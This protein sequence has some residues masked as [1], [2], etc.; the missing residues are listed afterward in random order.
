METQ[1][2]RTPLVIIGTQ[3]IGRLVLEAC[4]SI[5]RTV[6]CFINAEQSNEN[7]P[8][9]INNISVLGELDNIEILRM[10]GEKA[11]YFVALEE[12][13][14]RQNIIEMLKKKRKA[15]PANIIHAQVA[16]SND[17]EFGHGNYFAPFVVIEPNTKIH[18]HCIIHAGT[19]IGL[20]SEIKDFATIGAR[21]SIGAHAHIGENVYIGAGAIISPKIKI[22][23][24][25]QVLAGAVVLKDVEKGQTVFGNPALPIKN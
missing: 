13:Q 12:K 16:L 10:I 7:E 20:N 2:Q 5:D 9:E 3:A 8:V 14:A 6:Y 17:A 15:M 11:H 19:T 25:A 21:V 24:N 4:H 18:N 22:G 1:D 23:D